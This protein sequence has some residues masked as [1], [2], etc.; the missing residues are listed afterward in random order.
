MI[1]I[2]LTLDASL[3]VYPGDPPLEIE[4]MASLE[5]GPCNV[6]RVSMGVHSGTHADA[7]AHF[8]RGGATFLQIPLQ[9]YCGPCWVIELP[10]ARVIGRE[11]LAEA[12][13]ARGLVERVLLKTPNSRRW[14]TPEA[15]KVYQA[16]DVEA[17]EWLVGVG[18]KLVGIDALSIEHDHDGTFPVHHTLLGADV[19]ILEGL[20]LRNA[21]AGPYELLCLPLKLDTLDG[22]PVRAVLR[23]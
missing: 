17:A 18:V 11:A 8:V 3:P 14:G 2:S 7:P 20:D 6:S 15:G 9:R 10:E 4:L 1:D 22:G 5:T 16:L 12:W 21:A 23:P 19:L 13:P